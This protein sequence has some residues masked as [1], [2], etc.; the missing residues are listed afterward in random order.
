MM[1]YFVKPLTLEPQAKALYILDRMVEH[2]AMWNDFQ[3][4]RREIALAV[5]GNPWNVIWEVWQVGQESQQPNG[6]IMYTDIV[7]CV[8]A[9]GH[10]L[11]FDGKLRG[12]EGVLRES[13]RWAFQ[14]L[15]LH[16]ISAEVP[17]D[18]VTLADFARK[19]LGFRFEAE[20]RIIHERTK[21]GP[22]RRVSP[23][24]RTSQP[25]VREA[26]WGSRKYEAVRRRGQ[27]I[28]LLLLSITEDEFETGQSNGRS[29]TSAGGDAGE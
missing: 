27:W 25:S 18:A 20:G 22:S 8:D 28:D 6:I 3:V 4:G 10:F 15:K 14:N 2:E 26:S 23:V 16:R 12:K 7:P 17:A 1:A 29:N 19:V 9:K 13:M 5:L 21:R 24:P 11:F